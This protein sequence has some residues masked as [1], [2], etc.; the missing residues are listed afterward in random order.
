MLVLTRKRTETILCRAPSG[1]EVRFV[2]C[3]LRGDRARVGISAPPA[4]D[5]IREEVV[6]QLSPD[7]I[8]ALRRERMRRLAG[9]EEDSGFRIRDSG[10]EPGVRCTPSEVDLAP[11]PQ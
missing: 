7:H 10:E 6:E 3:D 9:E 8:A 1:E 5:I 11:A 2:I 4:W